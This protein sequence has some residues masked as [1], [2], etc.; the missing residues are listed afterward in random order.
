MTKKVSNFNCHTKILSTSIFNTKLNYL[1][2]WKTK[3]E[4]C[5]I[6]MIL[7]IYNTYSFL[8][9]LS[10]KIVPQQE[11]TYT[12]FLLIIYHEQNPKLSLLNLT[13]VTTRRQWSR[14]G[15]FFSFLF[16]PSPRPHIGP[17]HNPEWA[18][19]IRKRARWSDAQFR[20][21]DPCDTLE[22]IGPTRREERRV[23]TL[24]EHWLFLWVALI[25][26]L[27]LPRSSYSSTHP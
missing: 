1:I 16:W 3:L 8:V 25:C 23:I 13:N 10:S 14:H 5:S 19:V 27:P 6:Y 2:T 20:S 18:N 15:C 4:K 12:K 11:Y 22:T 26:P 9:S 17:R 7:F 21:P 24:N